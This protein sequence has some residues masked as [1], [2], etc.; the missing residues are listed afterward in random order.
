MSANE[1][2]RV[3]PRVTQLAA[4]FEALSPERR[5]I[6]LESQTSNGWPVWLHRYDWSKLK[7]AAAEVFDAIDRG[8]PA[9]LTLKAIDEL[10]LGD[11]QE[12]APRPKRRRRRG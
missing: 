1:T 5:S 4:F 6:L 2:I 12:D 3:G 7:Q 10:G 9:T 8:V 11:E